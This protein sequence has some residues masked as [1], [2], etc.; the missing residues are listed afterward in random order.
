MKLKT[1]YIRGSRGIKKGMGVESISINFDDFEP[2]I[3]G[4]MGPIGSGKTTIAEFLTPYL[5]VYSHPRRKN[6]PSGKRGELAKAF[7]LKDSERT[8]EFEIDGHLFISQILING[9]NG[10]LKAFLKKDGIELNED[11]NQDSYCDALDKNFPSP[12]LFY[13]SNF[14]TQKRKDFSQVEPGERKNL[15]L[16]MMGANALEAKSKF[17]ADKAKEVQRQISELSGRMAQLE[18]QICELNGVEDSI[19][20]GQKLVT[21]REVSIAKIEARIAELN[22]TL[23]NLEEQARRQVAFRTELESIDKAI[24]QLQLDKTSV[25]YEHKKK[26]EKLEAEIGVAKGNIAT[27]ERL[28]DPEKLQRMRELLAK[29]AELAAEI[30]SHVEAHGKHVAAKTELS[31]ASNELNSTVYRLTSV[32]EQAKSAWTTAKAASK[33]IYDVPCQ[34]IADAEELKRCSECQFLTDAI[35]AEKSLASLESDYRAKD[36]QLQDQKSILESKLKSAQDNLAA[37]PFDELRAKACKA[38]REDIDALKPADYIQRAEV[39]EEKLKGLR[40]KLADLELQHSIIQGEEA[41]KISGFVELIE[42]QVLQRSAIVS[43]INNAI[44]KGIVEAKD[45]LKQ[46]QV[47]EKLDRD[48]LTAARKDIESLQLKLDQRA[49]AQSKLDVCKADVSV[50]ESDLADWSH[51]DIGL[52]KNG[53]FA[54][55]LVESVGDEVSVFANELL[56]LFGKNWTI[57]ITTVKPTSDGDGEREGFF[58]WVTLDDGEV[59]ELA[60]LSGGQELIVDAILHHAFSYYIASN[61]GVALRTKFMDEADGSLDLE[62]AIQYH[63]AVELAHQRSN[64]NHTLIITHRP[65]LQQAI[66][67]RIRCVPGKGIEIERD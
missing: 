21:D 11:G 3:I 28:L 53:G 62:S 57:Q 43:Q 46:A 23:A 38:E 48:Q 30:E 29:R 5:F 22:T 18:A 2:G 15:L 36:K 66:S 47:A 31:T 61:S 6:L 25:G 34:K 40:D 20:I 1:A 32:A 54:A 33:L 4:L 37:N 67:Q 55:I 44:D 17:A 45:S 10:K 65:E 59:M 8:L 35:A 16:A 14:M 7:Y 41:V 9:E 56:A 58:V 49:E 51:L 19:A 60:D 64:L 26:L 27:Q 42:A 24:K 50:L 13:R 12:E 39:A 63:R 52:G